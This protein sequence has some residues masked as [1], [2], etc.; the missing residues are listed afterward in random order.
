MNVA[1]PMVDPSLKQHIVINLTLHPSSDHA[2]C[3]PQGMV[4]GVSLT[5]SMKNTW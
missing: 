5:L 1:S 3:V 4:G 2:P